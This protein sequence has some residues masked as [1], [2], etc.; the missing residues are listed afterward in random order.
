MRSIEHSLTV[1]VGRRFTPS[2]ARQW[3]RVITIVDF[4][5]AESPTRT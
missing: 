4:R 5:D 2:A 1:E 3:R